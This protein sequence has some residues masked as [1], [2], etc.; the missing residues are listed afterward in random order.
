MKLIHILL[1]AIAVIS[2]VDHVHGEQLRGGVVVERVERA[3]AQEIFLDEVGLEAAE[4][5]EPED[6]E[7][8]EDEWEGED[9][10]EFE[11]SLTPAFRESSDSGKVGIARMLSKGSKSSRS[12]KG[13]KSRRR[14]SKSSK[15]SKSSKA[16]RRRLSKSGKSSKG[17]KSR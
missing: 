3:P 7:S 14:L 2:A 8:I 12:S 1:S 17:S 16:S 13:S 10:E 15:G 4:E 6:G 5:E 11:E 9:E